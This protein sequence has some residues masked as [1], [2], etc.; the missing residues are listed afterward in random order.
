M[1]AD[2]EAR[3]ARVEAVL[4][5]TQLIHAGARANDRKDLA[6]M[7][8]CYWPGATVHHGGYNGSADGFVEYAGPIIARCLWAAHHVSNTTVEVSGARALAESH[9]FAHHRRTAASGEG[10]EDAFFEG[11]YIDL[12]ECRAGE[13]RILHRRGISD[14]ARAVPAMD[15]H[16][17]WARGMRSE[18]FPDDD[19]YRLVETFRI[20]SGQP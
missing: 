6:G 19:W 14:F 1:A 17:E 16:G 5:V 15:R 10:E 4:A 12:L 20:G 18:P 3:L 11:R 7:R 2:L 13:W 8:A 9:Y